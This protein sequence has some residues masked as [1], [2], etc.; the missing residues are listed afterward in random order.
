MKRFVAFP[1]IALLAILLLHNCSESPTQ[2]AFTGAE[3]VPF[4]GFETIIEEA[5]HD[6]TGLRA[7][8]GVSVGKNYDSGSP[9]PQVL[10]FA[11]ARGAQKSQDVFTDNR[12]FDMGDVF[13]TAAEETKQLDRRENSGFVHYG[14][15]LAPEF[16]PE[17]QYTF[18]ATG[19][20]NFPS[21]SF[22]MLGPR[23][24]VEIVEPA[25]DLDPENPFTV[26]WRTPNGT[27]LSV[28]EI[29]P[30]ALRITRDGGSALPDSIYDQLIDQV[31]PLQ[32]AFRGLA[33]Q[34]IIEPNDWRDM[35]SLIEPVP[36]LA[37]K[38][39]EVSQVRL[40]VQQFQLGA[41]LTEGRRILVYFSTSESRILNVD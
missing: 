7:L 28:V 37:I 27:D 34:A 38:T 40:F 29:H 31:K 20:S 18:Q 8:F 4:A 10:N 22:S 12:A 26:T 16:Q 30:L 24:I 32:K 33:R 36:A 3:E 9:E 15:S 1:L 14:P 39:I 23:F 35:V 17:T 11:F 2:P 41:V 6:T 19:S 25:T 5:G 13:L 21:F